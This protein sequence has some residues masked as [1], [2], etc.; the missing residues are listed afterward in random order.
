MNKEIVCVIPAKLTSE[1]CP[2]KNIKPFA[3]STLIDIKIEQAKRVGVFDRIV[4]N[5]DSDMIID[6]AKR[7]GVSWKL[8][9]YEYTVCGN[10][11]YH[12]YIAKSEPDSIVCMCNCTSPLIT[13]ETIV[14]CV[15]SYERI[16]DESFS[17]NTV[18]DI[19]TFVFDGNDPINFNMDRFPKSQDL[20][21]LYECNFGVSM[22]DSDYVVKNHGWLMLKNHYFVHVDKIEGL[23]IDYEEDFQICEFFYNRLRLGV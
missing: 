15:E 21:P 19:K 3:G 16:S 13:D 6:I 5:T 12:Q 1:R 7:H 8:R 18:S 20:R 2:M 4:V 23:D 11:E 22:A 10:H 14:K 17:V 9:P